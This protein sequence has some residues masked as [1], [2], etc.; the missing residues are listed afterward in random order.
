MP[1]FVQRASGRV[2]TQKAEQLTL[3]C[4][5]VLLATLYHRYY[6]NSSTEVH[7][8]SS[9]TVLHALLALMRSLLTGT[10]KSKFGYSCSN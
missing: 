5:V 10:F 6:L 7:S 1:S 2:C 8:D 4:S 3:V 9:I